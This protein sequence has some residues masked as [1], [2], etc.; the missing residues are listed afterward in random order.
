MASMRVRHL[1]RIFHCTCIR[2][3]PHVSTRISH[4]FRRQIFAGN[5]RAILRVR[6]SCPKGPKTTM[7]Q[8]TWRLC[9]SQIG[10][11]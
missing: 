10:E 11:R 6:C 7:L 4:A 8:N 1:P 2:Y 5:A 9:R 3:V